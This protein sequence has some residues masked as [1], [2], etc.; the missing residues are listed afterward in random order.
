MVG[1]LEGKVFV[2]NQY[3]SHSA[4]TLFVVQP[5]LHQVCL[6]EVKNKENN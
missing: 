6:K 3:I 2:S 4:M 5:R 1:C